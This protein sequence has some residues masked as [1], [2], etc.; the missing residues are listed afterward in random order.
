MD[1]SA[2]L[3]AWYKN[4]HR[5]LPWRNTRNPY[6]IWISEIILQQTR[7]NQGYEYYLRFIDRF[8]DVVSLAK[9]GEEEVLRLWQG[10]GYYSR[11]RNIYYAAHQIMTEFKGNF[12]E[13]YH[14]IIKLKGIGDYSASAIA[15]IA[16]KQCYPVIDGNVLR[17]ISR[18][19][20]ISTPVDSTESRKQTKAILNELIDK[21]HPDIFNQA[22]MEIGAMVCTPKSPACTV[23]PLQQF[24]FAFENKKT[25]ELPVKGKKITTQSRYFYYMVIHLK[26]KGRGTIYLNKRIKNDIWKNMYDFPLIESDKET[27]IN[28][29]LAVEL[30]KLLNSA[31]FIINSVSEEVKHKLSHQTIFA[32]FIEI[33]IINAGIEL[34]NYIET[35]DEKVHSLPIPKLIDNYLKTR[36]GVQHH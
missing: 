17:V 18:L 14:D 31:E 24:C 33:E 5:E 25:A 22:M 3:L 10:L 9:A 21:T 23:C 32:R 8:P 15:S 16:F 1:F 34:K 2:T 19:Y 20:G 28:Q 27:D 4:N 7:V 6:L 13:D 26:T 35:A 11:A 30:P 29:L 36:Q 12:P